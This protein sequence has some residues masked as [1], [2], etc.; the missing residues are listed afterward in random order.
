MIPFDE[1]WLCPGWPP[2]DGFNVE[3]TDIDT[4]NCPEIQASVIVTDEEGVAIVGLDESN[5]F[6]YED[7][8]KQI[9]DIET[10]EITS[11]SISASLVLDYSGSMTPEAIEAMENAAIGFVS[12]MEIGDSFEIIKFADEPNVV[13]EYTELIKKIDVN[14]EDDPIIK[15]IRNTIDFDRNF[16]FLY[17]AIYRGVSDTAEQSGNKAVIAMTDGRVSKKGKSKDDVITLAVDEGIPVFTI[18]L[19]DPNNL[20]EEVLKEIATKTGG[21]YYY[22]P[23]PNDLSDI[24]LKIKGALDNMYVVTYTTTIC[25]PDSSGDIM[26]ELNIEVSRDMAYGQDTREFYCPYI[27]DTN[28]IKGDNGDPLE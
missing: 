23:D 27:C 12:E 10:D 6:V 11:S 7:N 19:G 26:H 3:I 1:G 18:G 24:Y 5:L 17:D 20:N 4:S 21:I 16:T 13:Q 9:E 15:A 28:M 22:A 2:E 8:G 25:G 14:D